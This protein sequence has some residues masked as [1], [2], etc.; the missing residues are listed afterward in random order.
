MLLYF[1]L[2]GIVIIIYPFLTK[3]I[4]IVKFGRFV[5]ST[6]DIY[7][8]IISILMFIM[9]GCRSIQIGIDTSHYKEI[10]D[11]YSYMAFIEIFELE[12]VEIGY[13]V[14]NIIIAKVFGNFQWL[15]LV[16]AAIYIIPVTILIKKYSQKP[17]LSYLLF[18]CFGF[19]TFA[20]ST[21][22]QSIAMGI[23]ML[24][25]IF[26]EKRKVL[27]YILCIL[28]ASTF[29]ISALIFLPAYWITKVKI[30]QTT[31]V[32]FII[33][34]FILFL[35][36]D[37]IFSILNQLARIS[38]D[39]VD[40]GGNN[41]YIFILM[42]IILCYIYKTFR[43]KK[44]IN[45]LLQY[46]LMITAAIYP[47]TQFNPSVMRLYLYYYIFMILLIPN[48]LSSIRETE[49]RFLGYVG[50]ILIAFLFLFDQVLIDRMQIMPYYF[51]WQ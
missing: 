28:L 22:R 37:Y 19:F 42:T 11:N 46:M 16:S 44:E 27:W 33:S 10:Y 40:T 9:I 38:Y 13:S 29:H 41:Q 18:I 50:Y 31:T 2:I 23:I 8:Y 5:V 12:N 14:L 21:I 26:I 30:N 17:W 45:Q 35:A 32:L 25:F 39:T 49:I 24:A 1:M 4:S 3:K 34:A 47:I 6:K 43:E 20:M 51:F 48:F 7:C 15:L 36:K